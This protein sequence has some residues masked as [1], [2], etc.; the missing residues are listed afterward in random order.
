MSIGAACLDVHAEFLLADETTYD[1]LGMDYF[2]KAMK[3]KSPREFNK[4]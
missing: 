3:V 2:Y 4:V 1:Y